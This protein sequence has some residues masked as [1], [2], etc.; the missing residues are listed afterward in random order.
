MKYKHK[1]TNEI[2]RAQRF[3]KD[4]ADNFY[5]K[6]FLFFYYKQYVVYTTL[7]GELGIEEADKNDYVIF[8]EKED[9]IFKGILNKKYFNKFFKKC[10]E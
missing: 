7:S 4:M 10:E 2:I 5:Y 1:N 6:K 3:K 9:R 8:F